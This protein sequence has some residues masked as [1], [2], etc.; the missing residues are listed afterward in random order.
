MKTAAAM[1]ARAPWVLCV[2]GLLSLATRY[3]RIR[4]SVVRVARANVPALG[5]VP[6]VH[7]TTVAPSLADPALFDSLFG[8][9]NSFV[10][11]RVCGEGVLPVCI[12]TG[13]SGS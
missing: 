10:A 7:A 4:R 6:A 1:L 11:V 8:A 9:T 12:G 5:S 3:P 2:L 13:S